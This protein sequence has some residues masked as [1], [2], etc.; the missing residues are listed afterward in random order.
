MENKIFNLNSPTIN[1]NLDSFKEVNEYDFWYYY[2]SLININNPILSDKELTVVAYILNG[3]ENISYGKGEERKKLIS[4]IGIDSTNFTRYITSL[5]NK[6]YLQFQ[7]TRGDY[8]LAPTLR[9]FQKFIKES[10][11]TDILYTFTLPFKIK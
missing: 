11:N 5:V 3:N 4:D 8:L 7:G 6:G 9:K 1:K 2:L 10:K